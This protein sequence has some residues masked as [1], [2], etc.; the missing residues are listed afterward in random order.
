LNIFN[1]FKKPPTILQRIFLPIIVVWVVYV[2]VKYFQLYLIPPADMKLSAPLPAR[3]LEYAVKNFQYYGLVLIKMIQYIYPR[4]YL[5]VTAYG[6]AVISTILVTLGAVCLG[7]KVINLLKLKFYSFNERVLISSGLGFGF[8]GLIFLGFGMIGLVYKW[9]WYSFLFILIIESLGCF[10]FYGRALHDNAEKLG[11]RFL[12]L[13]WVNQTVMIIL[14]FGMILMG[15]LMLSP[16]TSWNE[17]AYHLPSA[18]TYIANHQVIYIDHIKW[19]NF[20]GLI[21]MHYTL[22]MLIGGPTGARLLHGVFGLLAAGAIVQLYRHY[23]GSRKL[24]L[25]A[26]IFFTMWLVIQVTITADTD[27]GALLFQL[28]AVMTILHTHTRKSYKG[29][30]IASGCML[31][32]ALG[33]G[34]GSL[35]FAVSIGVAYIIVAFW[36][37]IAWRKWV[38][39]T[40]WVAVSALILFSPWMLKAWLMT[41]NPIYPLGYGIFGGQGWSQTGYQYW[42]ADLYE[43]LGKSRNPVNFLMMPWDLTFNTAQFGENG[44]SPLLICFAPGLFFI[45]KKSSSRFLILLILLLITFNFWFCPQRSRYLLIVYA[46]MAILTASVVEKIFDN[47]GPTL[48]GILGILIIMTILIPSYGRMIEN[49]YW[50]SGVIFGDEPVNSYLKNS[51]ILP[52]IDMYDYINRN[53]P[54]ETKILAVY[55]SIRRYYCDAV[56]YS[57]DIDDLFYPGNDNSEAAFARL[58]EMDIEYVLVPEPE[59]V[60]PVG[61]DIPAEVKWISGDNVQEIHR[62]GGWKLI[63]VSPL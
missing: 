43:Q 11:K 48:R 32:F 35:S 56:I 46:L 49:C 29:W 45:R 40:V 57:W 3:P 6:P 60:P 13:A 5:L 22:A 54:K 18:K 12:K 63:K 21:N 17:L 7:E 24:L 61:P 25:P 34:W 20:P 42:T 27:L 26:A 37:K 58:S 38:I 36:E 53:L 1:Y 16:P 14:F 50:R 51:K 19:S 52:D 15:M 39:P 62:T 31:G 4:L 41:G 55:G 47:V 59:A 9:F 44:I 23:V 10:S 2:F 33:C 28:L 30:W 8:L